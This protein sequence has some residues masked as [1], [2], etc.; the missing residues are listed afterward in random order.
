MLLGYKRF[1]DDISVIA[2]HLLFLK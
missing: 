1:E 2:S